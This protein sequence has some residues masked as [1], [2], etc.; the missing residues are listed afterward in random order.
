[1]TAHRLNKKMKMHPSGSHAE[2]FLRGVGFLHNCCVKGPRLV[3][4]L[5]DSPW[6]PIVCFQEFL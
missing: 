5:T 3:R 6:L 2:R 1:M 4:P